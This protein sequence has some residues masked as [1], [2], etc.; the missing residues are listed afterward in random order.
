M[1][2][3]INNC[4]QH[5]QTFFLTTKRLYTTWNINSPLL[6]IYD[7]LFVF[8]SQTL[9]GVMGLHC[10]WSLPFC[11]MTLTLWFWPLSTSI[12]ASKVYL[13]KSKSRS[14]IQWFYCRQFFII[15]LK[16]K[17]KKSEK[18]VFNLKYVF[19]NSPLLWNQ[20]FEK[21]KKWRLCLGD[22]FPWS[23]K[24]FKKRN[25]SHWG[26]WSSV[27]PSTLGWREVA[28]LPIH[29]C[30]ITLVPSLVRHWLIVFFTVENFEKLVLAMP[31]I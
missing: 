17:K 4:V 11:K 8:L 10:I 29:I 22:L 21:E 30:Y 1:Y 23:H 18:Q 14:Y 9:K 12:M 15:L 26:L 27:P 24:V 25:S 28:F 31:K 13:F 16:K 2:I 19:L 7:F 5:V 3:T 6:N 20:R